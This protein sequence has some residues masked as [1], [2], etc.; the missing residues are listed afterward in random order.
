MQF[1]ET[2][3][4]R[5]WWLWLILVFTIVAMPLSLTGWLS[6]ETRTPVG[7]FE[8]A[9]ICGVPVLVLILFSLLRLETRID[10]VGV[11]YRFFPVHFSEKTILWDEIEGAAVRKYKPIR[12]YGGWG[13]RHGYKHGKAL[14]VS[15]DMGLQLMLKTGKKLLIGTQKAEEMELTL[16]DLGRFPL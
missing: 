16:R 4:F 5:Q 7:V 14:N 12:E 3:K 2:Q 13:F 9:L 1:T 15:G 11:H 6:K 8:I 10:S